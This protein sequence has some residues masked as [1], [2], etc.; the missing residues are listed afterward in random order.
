MEE[1]QCNHCAAPEGEEGVNAQSTA[2]SLALLQPPLWQ[3]AASW[4]WRNEMVDAGGW[5]QGCE[6][7]GSHGEP[8]SPLD[9]TWALLK[10]W[11]VK[12]F[13]SKILTVEFWQWAALLREKSQKRM[14]RVVQDD[15]KETVT[16]KN[17]LIT[18]NVC[19][20]PSVNPQHVGCLSCRLKTGNRG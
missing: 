4:G 19:R 3:Q 12:Y 15:W 11:Y 9:K 17:T 13:G 16:Q 20:G 6:L 2:L 14:A 7:Q 10:T 1:H 18:A 8:G 5:K